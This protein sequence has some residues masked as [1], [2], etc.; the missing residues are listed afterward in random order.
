MALFLLV[1]SVALKNSAGTS[2]VVP[3]SK[4]TLQ[5]RDLALHG[6]DPWLGD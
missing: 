2:L 5:C 1:S 6:F 3:W 4:I